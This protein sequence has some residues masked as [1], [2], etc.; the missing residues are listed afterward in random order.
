MN[1]RGYRSEKFFELPD[2]LLLTYILITHK[3]KIMAPK[4][5]RA[6]IFRICEYVTLNDKKD[7]FFPNIN[8]FKILTWED[9]PVLSRW[10][11]CCPEGNDVAIMLSIV[12]IRITQCCY[13]KEV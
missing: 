12:V 3:E 2:F 4:D 10:T 11:H 6:L 7:V 1:V 9:Y 5:V 13:K 8:K